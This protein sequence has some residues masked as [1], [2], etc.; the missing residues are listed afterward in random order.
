LTFCVAE[1]P[2]A[3]PYTEIHGGNRPFKDGEVVTHDCIVVG[4]NPKPTLNWICLTPPQSRNTLKIGR[5]F[6]NQISIQLD[7]TE[8]LYNCAC[9]AYHQTW[10][11]SITVISVSLLSRSKSK[12]VYMF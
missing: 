7:N 1:R 5:K 9:H 11:H 8:M 12:V 10:T 6:I 4:G 2:E 3:G